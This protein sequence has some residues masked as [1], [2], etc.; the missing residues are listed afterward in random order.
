M[1]PML[2]KSPPKGTTSSFCFFSSCPSL[3]DGMGRPPSR[4]CSSA[5]RLLPT[6]L[7][8]E[9]LWSLSS[10]VVSTLLSS[11]F[12]R[13]FL[14]SANSLVYLVTSFSRSSTLEGSPSFSLSASWFCT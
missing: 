13:V 11:I 12:L 6:Y 10:L 1:S 5:L 3:V 8:R 4:V 9:S 2:A 14:S 7:N